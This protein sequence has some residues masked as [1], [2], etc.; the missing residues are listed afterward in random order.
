M[1]LKSFVDA[2]LPVGDEGILTLAYEAPPP[3]TG[4]GSRAGSNRTR[5]CCTHAR[6]AEL[7]TSWRGESK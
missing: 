6:V 4:T 7:A 5:R 3:G 2:R 1:M